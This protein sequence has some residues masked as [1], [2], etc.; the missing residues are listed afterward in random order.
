M[1]AWETTLKTLNAERIGGPLTYRHSR[2][3]SVTT[4]WGVDW[5]DEFI[6]RDWNEQFAIYRAT[7]PDG[8]VFHRRLPRGRIPDL[9]MVL[10]IEKQF[11]RIGKKTRRDRDRNA[12]GEELMNLFYAVFV[13]SGLRDSHAGQRVVVEA[14]RRCWL[15]GQPRV[16]RRAHPAHRE[17]RALPQRPRP[18]RSPLGRGP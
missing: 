2:T 14:A 10:V 9:P 8:H 12:F 6:A 1:A 16:H 7:T 13:R 4:S 3:S 11:E 15:R 5:D 18:L 17:R